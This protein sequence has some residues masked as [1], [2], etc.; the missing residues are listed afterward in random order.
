MLRTKHLPHIQ[1]CR[2]ITMPTSSAHGDTHAGMI[3]AGTGARY[4]RLRLIDA[5]H[6]IDLS[7]DRVAV[8]LFKNWRAGCSWSMVMNTPACLFS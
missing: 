2:R 4:H 5:V 6:A 7:M 8:A 3:P 1:L